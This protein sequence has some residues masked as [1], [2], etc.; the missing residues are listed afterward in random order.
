MQADA[1]VREPQ[2]FYLHVHAIT[3][4]WNQIFF[5]LFLHTKDLNTI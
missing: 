5:P 4:E 2:T 1:N 3:A